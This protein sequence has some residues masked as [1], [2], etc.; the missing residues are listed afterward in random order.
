MLVD[1]T[2]IAIVKADSKRGGRDRFF[3]LIVRNNKRIAS[4]E[5]ISYL[6]TVRF[7]HVLLLEKKKK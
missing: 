7:G 3:D 5:E 6:P 4:S 2:S 1:N